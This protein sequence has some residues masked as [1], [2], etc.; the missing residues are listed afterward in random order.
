MSALRMESVAPRIRNPRTA[1]NAA[2]RR[3]ARNTRSRYAT[4]GYITAGVTAALVVLL[5][6]VLLTA[7][8][9]ALA[10]SID[11]TH[12]EQSEMQAQVARYDD[13]IASLTSDDRLASVA[14][15]LG[16]VQ[17]DR[18]LRISLLPQPQSR[19]LAYVPR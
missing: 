19:P 13:E 8:I 9:T 2:Q 4:H 14:A 1:R 5:S 7:N 11:R 18:F 3:I 17:P 15:K 10:Y 12:E 6:Y 16:M